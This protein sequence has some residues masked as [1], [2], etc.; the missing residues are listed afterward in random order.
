MMMM[1]IHRVLNP[2]IH[3]LRAQYLWAMNCPIG[4]IDDSLE[5]LQHGQGE[6]TCWVDVKVWVVLDW[7]L[8]IP[9]FSLSRFISLMR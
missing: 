8:Q 4:E 6:P 7:T 5:E 9:N 2:E 1:G 3:I